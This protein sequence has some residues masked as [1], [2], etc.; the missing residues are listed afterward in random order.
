MP[1]GNYLGMR[2]VTTTLLDDDV[3]QLRVALA[4]I[5][6]LV[7]RQ[8]AGDGMTRT[9]LSVLGTIARLGAV[10]VGDLAD[11]EGLNPTMLSR[12][13]GKLEDAGLVT[14]SPGA[15]DR[16]AVQVQITPA[17]TA[18]H[19]RLRRERTALFAERLAELPVE[20]AD[21]VLAAVPALE[22]LAERMRRR[23]D[24]SAVPANARS[25]A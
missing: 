11:V 24:R 2:D 23:D 17:G 14:R 10:G 20:Q 4:R 18:L 1:I 9:Q 15:V 5:A 12:I 19:Q 16:R 22:A 21:A 13:V 3:S 6:R 25:I 8:V 7:D